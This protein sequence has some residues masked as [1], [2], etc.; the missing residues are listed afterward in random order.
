LK[1]KYKQTFHQ[2]TKAHAASLLIRKLGDKRRW[3]DFITLGTDLSPSFF[4]FRWARDAHLG[5]ER[6][7]PPTLSQKSRFF[8]PGAVGSWFAGLK[9][10]RLILVLLSH[11]LLKYYD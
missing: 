10:S 8:V 9:F 7:M 5:L 11:F 3:R 1:R 2:T 6:L 4:L